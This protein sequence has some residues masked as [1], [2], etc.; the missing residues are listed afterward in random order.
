MAALDL[1]NI[2]GVPMDVIPL[3]IHAIRVAAKFF[4]KCS[5]QAYV[6][7]MSHL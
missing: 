5:D 2:P 1:P 6:G 3:F 7:E 4:S